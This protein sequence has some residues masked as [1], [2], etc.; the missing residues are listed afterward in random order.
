MM[1]MMMTMLQHP[2]SCILASSSPHP[3]ATV[4]GIQC[5]CPG[6]READDIHAHHLPVLHSTGFRDALVTPSSPTAFRSQ[7][8]HRSPIS[9]I[10]LFHALSPATLIGV[11]VGAKAGSPPAAIAC[12]PRSLP[13][14]TPPPN[15]MEGHANDSNSPVRGSGT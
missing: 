8:N 13:S 14:A 3:H 11:I 12:A 9:H 15:N 2:P 1:M 4:L 7:P 6:P 10:A 5:S